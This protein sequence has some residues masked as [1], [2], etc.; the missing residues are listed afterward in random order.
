MNG[1]FDEAAA[2]KGCRHIL[3]RTWLDRV[4]SGRCWRESVPARMRAGRRNGSLNETLAPPLPA[5]PTGAKSD[6]SGSFARQARQIP[7]RL[8]REKL[9]EQREQQ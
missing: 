9:A 8:F 7:R 3:R 6:F 5:K 2:G 1:G 4:L